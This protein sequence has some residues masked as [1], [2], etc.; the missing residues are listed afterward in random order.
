MVDVR[1]LDGI[2]IVQLQDQIF[3]LNGISIESLIT[4]SKS[5][6]EFEDLMRK[7]LIFKTKLKGDDVNDRDQRECKDNWELYKI[8]ASRC[9][10]KSGLQK[11]YLT[12]KT[13]AANSSTR[14][15][16]ELCTV[17]DISLG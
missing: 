9:V 12:I 4:S 2:V 14:T 10:L 5:K 6:G 8:G 17:L 13:Y 1:I 3:I 16:I 7:K 11:L 15:K